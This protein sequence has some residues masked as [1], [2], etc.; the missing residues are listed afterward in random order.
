MIC[1]RSS[2]ISGQFDQFH[3]AAFRLEILTQDLIGIG[4][5]LFLRV[6]IFVEIFFVFG[7][8]PV[9]VGEN[10]LDDSALVTHI[11][12]HAQHVFIC[13]SDQSGTEYNGQVANFHLVGFAMVD[14][15]DQML[16]QMMQSFVIEPG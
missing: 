9:K 1:F 15:S 2:G 3:R 11:R 6:Q 8:K 14:H 4:I 16:A 7:E 5:D 12:D 13:R 10:G